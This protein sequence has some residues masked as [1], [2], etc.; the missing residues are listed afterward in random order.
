MPPAAVVA[1]GAEPLM[2]AAA[3]MVS[4]PAEKV[5]GLSSATLPAD[6]R[7]TVLFRA[8]PASRVRS[9]DVVVIE[10]LAK[11]EPVPI[12]PRAMPRRR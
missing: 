8:A 10:T 1:S 4:E 11:A 5:A 7:V 9:P 12:E 2:A 3:V 6:V